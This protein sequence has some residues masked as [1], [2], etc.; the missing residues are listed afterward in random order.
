MALYLRRQRQALFQPGL[1]LADLPRQR[2]SGL[3]NQAAVVVPFDQ[4]FERQGD[5]NAQYDR[6]HVIKKIFDRT[7]RFLGRMNVH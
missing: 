5:Q 4:A 3:V 6:E 1:V 7:Y 2:L